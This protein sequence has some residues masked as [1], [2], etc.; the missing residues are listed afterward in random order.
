MD[1]KKRILITGASGLLGYSLCEYYAQ[2]DLVFGLKNTHPIGISGVQEV[3]VDLLDKAALEKAF[4]SVRPEVVIHTAGLT[5][6]D[7]CEANPEKARLLNVVATESVGRLSNKYGAKLVHI[8]TD[9]LFDGTQKMVTEEASLHPL[10]EYARTKAAAEQEALRFP[11]ALVLRTN[12]YGKGRAWRASFSD[13]LH[14][15]LA[16]GKK[17]RCFHD[18]Y[19]TP[20]AMAHLIGILNETLR[21]QAS[22]IFNLCGSER[23]SKFEFAIRYAER[24]KFPVSLIESASVDSVAL[25]AK[26]PKDMSL[27]TE[28]LSRLLGRPLPGVDAGL[29]TL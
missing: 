28:K 4:D 27:S 20:I 7:E 17:I 14:Q 2:K 3:S 10:N 23:V 25:K 13:W 15:N 11:N 5:Q 29:S 9:H 6:V 16:D 19:F 18:V 21:R 1:S 12:F 24:F 22:G 8:S 26:R